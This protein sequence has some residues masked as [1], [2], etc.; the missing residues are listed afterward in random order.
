LFWRE[1]VDGQKISSIFFRSIF[2]PTHHSLPFLLGFLAVRTDLVGNR[3]GGKL[4]WSDLS[5]PCQ[6]LHVRYY[7][8]LTKPV[9]RANRDQNIKKK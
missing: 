6:K 1:G 4:G 9:V 5:I 3:C 7:N 2:N 8:T